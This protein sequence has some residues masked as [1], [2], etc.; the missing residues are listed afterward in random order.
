MKWSVYVGLTGGTV[1]TWSWTAFCSKLTVAGGAS[2]LNSWNSE[3]NL[4]DTAVAFC[5]SLL[6]SS[7]YQGAGF[8][9]GKVL[10]FL[11]KDPTQLLTWGDI[12]SCLWSIPA[13]QS[14]GIRFVGGVAGAIF[15]DIY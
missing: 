7:I 5:S 6:L 13:I 14:G 12:A 10:S 11:P 2:L 15:N 8:G 3:T 1:G 9:F 4:K